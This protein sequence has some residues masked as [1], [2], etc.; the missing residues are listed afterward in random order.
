MK[1]KRKTMFQCDKEY[2]AARRGLRVLA[3]AKGK[4]MFAEMRHLVEAELIRLGY[5]PK[6]LRPIKD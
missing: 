3:K 2:I 4:L 5:D 1:S 6:T